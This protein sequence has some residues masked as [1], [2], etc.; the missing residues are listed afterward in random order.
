MNIACWLRVAQG[1]SN[2]EIAVILGAS[3]RTINQHMENI[4]A[5]LGVENRASPIITAGERLRRS[6]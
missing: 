6:R 5:R 4:F 1:K 3:S 2:A